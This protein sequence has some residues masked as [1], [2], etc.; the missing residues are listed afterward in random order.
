MYTNNL[1]SHYTDYLLEAAKSVSNSWE[2]AHDNRKFKRA[3]RFM[4]YWTMINDELD[5]IADQPAG[6][7]ARYIIASREENPMCADLLYQLWGYNPEPRYT[8]AAM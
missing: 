8:L 5:L 6:E 7:V 4:R 2:M 3:A 1:K